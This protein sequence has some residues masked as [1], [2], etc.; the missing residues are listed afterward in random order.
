MRVIR[1]VGLFLVTENQR[2]A[3]Q[4]EPVY[5]VDKLFEGIRSVTTRIYKGLVVIEKGCAKV[6]RLSGLF[7]LAFMH[8]IYEIVKAFGKFPTFFANAWRQ[9]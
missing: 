4:Q 8:G 6:I 7:L 5:T 9:R 2:T 1:D 3:S